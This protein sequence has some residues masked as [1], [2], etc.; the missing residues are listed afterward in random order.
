MTDTDLLQEIMTRN[1]NLT[2]IVCF[3]CQSNRY[4]WE[5]FD[6]SFWRL[7]PYFTALRQLR[8]VDIGYAGP[9][10]GYRRLHFLG[11]SLWHVR[12][13][14]LRE[15]AL[16]VRE[17]ETLAKLFPAVIKF[18]LFDFKIAYN[19][20][21]ETL[22]GIPHF[23]LAFVNTFFEP[24]TKLKNLKILFLE[25]WMPRPFQNPLSVLTFHRG[26]PLPACLAF[27]F[28]N[29]QKM[30]QLRRLACNCF[31]LEV[32]FDAFCEVAKANPKEMHEFK[33]F[34]EYFPYGKI[35]LREEVKKNKPRNVCFF[36]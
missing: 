5:S 30:P 34:D 17:M 28:L 18:A 11:Q 6:E 31:D 14:T 26:K 35:V 21:V 32:C 25:F 9:E 2:R 1:P 24:L 29:P 16:T 27:G 7:I 4:M 19:D 10:C 23:F 20:S 3:I 15:V 22:E 13:L 12:S 8:V 36:E 33:L